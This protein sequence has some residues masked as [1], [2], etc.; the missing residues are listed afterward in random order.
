MIERERLVDDLIRDEGLR[1]H[2]Y[3]PKATV[4]MRNSLWAWQ[5]KKGATRLMAQKQTGIETR[6]RANE[7]VLCVS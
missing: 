5:A 1:C 7:D 4:A 2:A 3:D 6:A